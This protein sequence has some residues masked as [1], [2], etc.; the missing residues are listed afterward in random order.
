[1]DKETL[2]YGYILYSAYHMCESMHFILVS[3]MVISIKINLDIILI[4]SFINVSLE[5]TH[6]EV[7]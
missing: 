4:Y 6:E 3:Y 5:A 7:H 2:A 1:M